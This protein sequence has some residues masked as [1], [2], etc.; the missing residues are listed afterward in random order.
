MDKYEFKEKCR[1]G[2]RQEKGR[3]EKAIY[4]TPFSP[5]LLTPFIPVSFH[6]F[7][8]IDYEN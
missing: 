6:P 7:L 8:H 4:L 1:K 2:G 5:L 3:D